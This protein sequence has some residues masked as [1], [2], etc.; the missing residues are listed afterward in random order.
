MNSLANMPLIWFC[1]GNGL[2]RPPM[3]ALPISGA[4]TVVFCRWRQWSIAA[5]AVLFLAGGVYIGIN[6]GGKM[7]E[8][9]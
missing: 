2:P 5:V 3:L 6:A 1:G 8:S 4:W 9:C 7:P